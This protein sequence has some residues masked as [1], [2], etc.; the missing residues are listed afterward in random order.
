MFTLMA[1]LGG[2]RSRLLALVLLLAASFVL[3][4]LVFNLQNLALAPDLRPGFGEESSPGG[5]QPR[6]GIPWS[7]LRIL[8]ISFLLILVTFIVGGVLYLKSKGKGIHFPLHELIGGLGILVAFL[9]LYLVLMNLGGPTA[10]FEGERELG[11]PADTEDGVPGLSTSSATPIG[12]IFVGVAFG[13]VLTG[14]LLSRWLSQR[15]EAARTEQTVE[16]ARR[17]AALSLEDAIYRLDIGEDVRSVILRCYDEMT[18]LFREKGLKYGRDL[19]ARELESLVR[20]SLRLSDAYAVRLRELFEEARYS[21]HSMSEKSKEMAI[22]C[23]KSVK[24]SLDALK[25]PHMLAGV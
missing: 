12:L 15:N 7:V 24:G 18:K 17:R 14:V 2:A 25:R 21:T 23:L 22:G 19:T 11:Y 1:L 10:T 8:L 6:L 16:E 9:V 3:A 13:I 5:G 4:N 20:K